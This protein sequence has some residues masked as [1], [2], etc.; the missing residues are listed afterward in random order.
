[1]AVPIYI[2][3]NCARGFPFLYI[4]T[5]TCY[6]L[7]DNSHYDRWEVISHCGFVYHFLSDSDVEHLLMET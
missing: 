4:L 3:T 1:M 2:P 5:N 6:Y 7:F